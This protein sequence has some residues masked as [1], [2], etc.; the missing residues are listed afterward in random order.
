MNNVVRQRL[1]MAPMRARRIEIPTME[2]K[3]GE[4]VQLD[5]LKSAL[6]KVFISEMIPVVKNQMKDQ[7]IFGSI[8]DF[9]AWYEP[10]TAKFSD[11]QNRA[12]SSLVQTRNAI[13]VGCN[14]TRNIR[15][16]KAN[17]FF[18]IF[19]ERNFNT[20]LPEVVRQVADV[21]KVVFG[22]FLTWPYTQKN[23]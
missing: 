2:I 15:E 16:V 4:P 6:Q 7:I 10:L 22:N 19:W 5:E 21:K 14:C 11:E 20:D 8:Y 3:K 12:F 9:V 17:E 1:M 13:N 18:K 23:P